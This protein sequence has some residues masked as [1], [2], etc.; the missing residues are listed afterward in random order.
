MPILNASILL[1][2]QLFLYLIFRLANFCRLMG[3]V[4]EEKYP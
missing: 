1:N 3:T 4:T 2:L